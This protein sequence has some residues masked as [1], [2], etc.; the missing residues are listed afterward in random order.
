[1]LH[2]LAERLQGMLRAS[3]TLCRYGGEEFALILPQINPE[4]SGALLERLRK[5]IQEMEVARADGS[6]VVVTISVGVASLEDGL[7]AGQLVIRADKSLYE[8]KHAVAIA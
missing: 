4:N 1:M 6:K 2:G 7:S 8:S 5:A 3:D